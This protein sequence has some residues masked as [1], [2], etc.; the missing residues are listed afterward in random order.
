MT[1]ISGRRFAMNLN[2]ELPT[3]ME[4]MQSTKVATSQFR[5]YYWNIL[6]SAPQVSSGFQQ[7]NFSLTSLFLYAIISILLLLILG[8]LGHCAITS[9][10]PKH[11]YISVNWDSCFFFS[12]TF[13]PQND[14]CFVRPLL[15]TS[16]K[17]P[18]EKW[19]FLIF[20]FP[21]P[22]NLNLPSGSSIRVFVL[23]TW[24]CQDASFGSLGPLS[25]LYPL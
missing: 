20:N 8:S 2:F 4:S 1:L 11:C 10:P 22:V 16:L 17:V 3:A 23:F 25:S 19:I 5:P 9:Y 18:F 6:Q 24:R 7:M 12:L 15:L 21:E 14:C 13:C